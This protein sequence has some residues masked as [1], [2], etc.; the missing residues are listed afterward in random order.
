MQRGKRESRKTKE[1]SLAEGWERE[2]LGLERESGWRHGEGGI[3]E[4]HLGNN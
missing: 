1:E 3:F 4:S 2:I